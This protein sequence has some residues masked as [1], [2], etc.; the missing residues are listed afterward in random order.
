MRLSQ[1][2]T[3]RYRGAAILWLPCKI[4]LKFFFSSEHFFG[5]DRVPEE[6]ICPLARKIIL[7]TA[8]F[9]LIVPAT[10]ADLFP[11]SGPVVSGN[12]ARLRFG[13][14]AAPK[15]A[16]LSVKRAIWAANQLHSK[17][18]GECSPAI[19]ADLIRAA[20]SPLRSG[21]LATS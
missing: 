12:I 8:V 17:P 14:A 5:Y 7:G 18:A 16:P 1:D 15:K 6:F 2:F 3:H 4:L 19:W 13:R 9:A 11:L 20:R 21:A 10:I